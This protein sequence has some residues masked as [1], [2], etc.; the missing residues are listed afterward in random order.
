MPAMFG[1][2]VIGVSVVITAYGSRVAGITG[3][4]IMVTTIL[5]MAMPTAGGGKIRR[6]WGREE[7]VTESRRWACSLFFNEFSPGVSLI[8]GCKALAKSYKC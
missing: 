7:R 3:V 8:Y 1:R 2:R 6:V 5:F 4:R